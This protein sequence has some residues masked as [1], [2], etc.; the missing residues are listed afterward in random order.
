[1]PASVNAVLTYGLERNRTNPDPKP[2]MEDPPALEAGT[3]VQGVT[4]H[5][6][7][8][9]QDRGTGG[10]RQREG[11]LWEAVGMQL[12]LLR[13]A[14]MGVLPASVLVWGSQILI[15]A[16]AGHEGL[17]ADPAIMAVKIY[18][19]IVDWLSLFIYVPYM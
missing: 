12:T 9:T 7:T 17:N 11:G 18:F 3:P 8:R 6:S 4:F 16:S 1:M 15:T 19:V 10:D 5:A 13:L 2:G 14:A